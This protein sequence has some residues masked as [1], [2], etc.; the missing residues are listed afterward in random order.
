[1]KRL[2]II[3]M[4]TAVPLTARYHKVTRL[5]EFEKL[6]DGYEYSVACFASSSK[7]KGEDISSDDLKNRQKKF[8]NLQEMLQS[9]ASKPDFKKFLSK[10]IGFIAVD[11][12]S[13]YGQDFIK[14]FYIGTM[15]ICYAFQEGAQDKEAKL[16]HPKSTKD[17]VD[18]LEDTA[19]NELNNLLAERKEEKNQDRQERIAQYYAYGGFYPYGWGYGWGGSSYYYRPYWGWGYLW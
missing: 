9:A 11:V 15:P 10:D 13:K 12:T 7:Q 6:V 18:L 14:D 4:I 8:R 19:G 17:L 2:M 16:V 5:Q 1:M 3:L